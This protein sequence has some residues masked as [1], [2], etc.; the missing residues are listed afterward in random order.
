M[1]STT[2]L[3]KEGAAMRAWK[4]VLAVLALALVLATPVLA[5]TRKDNIDVIIALDKSL[6]MENK[7]D[8]VKSWVNSFIIDQLIVPGDFLDVTA[9]YGKADII[10]S[11]VIKDD[12]D[13]KAA[14]AVISQVRGNG[15][16]TDIG[17]AL[18]VVKAE[19]ATKEKDGRQKYVLLLTDGIQEAP[20]SSKYWSKN[21]AFNHEFLANT[22]TIMQ[23]GW[24]V[25]IL[26]IGIDTAAKDLAKE[27]QGSYSEV[28]NKLTPEEINQK[29]GTLFGMPIVE[30]P[31]SLGAISADGS[32]R[33]AF[34]LRPSG[35]AGDVRIT[36]SD[37]SVQAGSRSIPGLLSA[38]VTIEVKKDGTTAVTIPLHFPPALQPGSSSGTLTFGFGTPD[39]F[40]PA[41]FPVTLHVMGW[42][43]SNTIVMGG[44]LLLLLLVAALVV[45]LI[46]RLKRGKPLRFVVLIENDPVHEAPISLR[47]GRELFLNDTASVFSLVPQRNARSVAKFTVKD[48]K[49]PLVILKQDRFPKLKESL[50]DSLGQ[51]IVL[52]AESG[53]NLS[54]KVR[55]EE[56]GH[57]GEKTPSAERTPPREKVEPKR[58]AGPR[59][60]VSPKEKVQSKER[61]K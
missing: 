29:A 52:R 24:K 56:S 42:V 9:F 16:Y 30:G 11:Q 59:A 27:L 15:K 33:V 20:P 1:H 35:L 5:D 48:G 22:K 25:M 58:K 12:A 44:G 47:G 2:K 32:S 61:K 18:D 50:P 7:V 34:T 37:A 45:I 17:N 21:G 40:A 39:R 28:S 60:K 23:K 14:K 41:Q 10:I 46:W 36:V 43:Q 19:I 55:P 57:P 6:S 51:T 31:M 53:K 49:V 13:R 3:C 38:P 26:G 54:L 4:R 8:A